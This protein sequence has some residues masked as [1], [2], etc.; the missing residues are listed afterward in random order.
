MSELKTNYKDAAK[1]YELA[2]RQVWAKLPNW[3]KAVVMDCRKSDSADRNTNR[4]FSEY[5]TDVIELAES[6]V[7]LD[8]SLPSVPIPKR[9]LSVEAEPEPLANPS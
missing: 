1:R 3:K 7:A 5:A 9:N 4:I 2:E 6:S 8:E